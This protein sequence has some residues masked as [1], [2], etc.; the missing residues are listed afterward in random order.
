MPLSK[1]KINILPEQLCNQ[2][3]AGEVVER[4]A[5]VVKELIE[6]SLDA[7]ASEIRVEVESGGKKLI[8]VADDGV[9]MGREDLL[10]SLERHATSKISSESDLFRLSSLGFRG[11]ALPSIASVSRMRLRS[12]LRDELAGHEVYL[13]GGIVKRC[14]EVGTPHGTTIEIRDLFFNT[15]ARRKFLRRDETELSHISDI[16]TKLALA[17]PAVQFQLAHNGR[18]VLEL[19]RH[20]QLRERVVAVLGRKLAPELLEFQPAAADN[21]CLSG[22]LA[23]PNVDRS[24]PSAVYT[25]INGRFVQDRTVR[26][27]L[28]EG[29]RGLLMKGRYPVAV[30]FLDIDPALVDVNVHPAKSEVRFRDQRLVHDFIVS[31]VRERI[32]EERT[33]AAVVHPWLATDPPHLTA[34]AVPSRPDTASAPDLD[35]SAAV[36]ESLA[37]YA[38]QMTADEQCNRSAFSAPPG[39]PAPPAGLSS[40]PQ[41][42]QHNSA[43]FF[44]GLKIIGQY[45]RSYLLCEDAGDLVVIDQHAAHERIGFEALR[46]QF[47]RGQIERQGLLVPVMI[48]FDHKGAALLNEYLPELERFGFEVEP[49]GGTTFAVKGTPSILHE[50]DFEK[51]L[52]DLVAEL[53]EVGGTEMLM[54]AVEQVLVTIACHRVV[55]ANQKLS[56]AEMRALLRQLDEVD[57]SQHCPHGRPVIHRLSGGDVERFFRR[58]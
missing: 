33:P 20:R 31:S 42:T 49:F 51:L 36:Q 26:H 27:A 11:E 47:N 23:R 19:Y 29:Y 46:A 8:L 2:I 17:N 9:G 41:Q 18:V 13:E 39:Q 50:A 37:R 12:R 52:L 6:N 56:E 28:L 55:R 14:E 5:S 43:G 3:A 45:R 35:R 57:F 25:Y 22:L 34:S 7:D 53:D 38:R 15:P 24:N 54:S 21:L 44:A 48:E 4:P 30:I 40:P 1:R 10:L 58:T 16:I 32:R